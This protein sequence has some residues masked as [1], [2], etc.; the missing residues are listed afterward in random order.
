VSVPD[1]RIT[2]KGLDAA[3]RRLVALLRLR[4]EA[5]RKGRE[6]ERALRELDRKLADLQRK[7]RRA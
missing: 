4:R 6:L 3:E 1:I 7:T 2:V 5:E